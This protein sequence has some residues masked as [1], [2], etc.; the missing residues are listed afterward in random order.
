MC[1]RISSTSK[2]NVTWF[3]GIVFWWWRGLAERSHR[4]TI[5]VLWRI[6]DLGWFISW[7]LI[8]IWCNYRS[9]NCDSIKFVSRVRGNERQSLGA[10]IRLFFDLSCEKFMLMEN[11]K[12]LMNELWLRI[13]PQSIWISLAFSALNAALITLINKA[14]FSLGCASW[15]ERMLHV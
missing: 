6:K 12:L 15:S 5:H 11:R 13:N 7:K 9:I 10:I 2:I 14:E 8:G 3:R 4:T 1:E